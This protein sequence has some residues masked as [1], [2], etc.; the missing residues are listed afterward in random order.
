MGAIARAA[1]ASDVD[2][3]VLS[4]TCT[5][6]YHRRTV[7][8]SMGDPAHACPPRRSTGPEEL[9]TLHDNEFETWALTPGANAEE[10]WTTNVPKRLAILLGA[11]APG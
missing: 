7:R 8:V 2:G 6:P 10:L 3:M 1:R 9:D 11:E 4:P 5:D